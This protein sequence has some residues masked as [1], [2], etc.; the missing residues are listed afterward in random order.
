MWPR[1]GTIAIGSDA[2]LTIIDPEHRVRV[3]T[4]R[5][6]SASDFEPHEGYEVVGWPVKT[7]LRGRVV[8]ED[9]ELRAEPGS[10]ELIRRGTYRRP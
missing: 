3:A 1:K 4:E 6:Q 2:D 5:M 9:V 10:G 8:V 7:I